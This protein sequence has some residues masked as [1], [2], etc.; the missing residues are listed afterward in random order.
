M[1]AGCTSVDHKE[2]VHSIYMA[3]KG[4]QC[5]VATVPYLRPVYQPCTPRRDIVFHY[6]LCNALVLNAWH[7]RDRFTLVAI[8]RASAPPLHYEICAPASSIDA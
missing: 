1:T 8:I 4:A 7:L 5:Q 6:R 3:W 2:W